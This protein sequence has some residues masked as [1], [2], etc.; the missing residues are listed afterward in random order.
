M[1]FLK[2]SYISFAN[3]KP[4]EAYKFFNKNFKITGPSPA[5]WG[6]GEHGNRGEKGRKHEKDVK[7]N[8]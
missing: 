4:H 8:V 2:Q 5:I 3:Q 6:S 7:W 1:P